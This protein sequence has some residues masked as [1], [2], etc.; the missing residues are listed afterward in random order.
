MTTGQGSRV[1]VLALGRDPLPHAVAEAALGWEAAGVSLSVVTL[2]PRQRL[3]ATAEQVRLLGRPA[4]PEGIDP[5]T[6][7]T[8][9]STV[10]KGLRKLHLDPVR[11]AAAVL[12]L[13]SPRARRLLAGA[14][15]VLAADPASVPLGWVLAHRRGKGVVFRT[16]K[17]ASRALN[18][19]GTP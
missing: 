19:T 12:A 11:W 15:V 5:S 10:R 17:A 16:A 7:G 4:G 14:D 6:T 13:S 1:L 3:T 2:T 8:P 18:P 9:R